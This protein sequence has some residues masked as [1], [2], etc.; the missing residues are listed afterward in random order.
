MTGAASVSLDALHPEMQLRQD[1]P[2]QRESCGPLP[3]GGDA[4][5]AGT[6]RGG[7]SA[8]IMRLMSTLDPDHPLHVQ[9]DIAELLGFA[10]GIIA[11]GAVS[12][13]E[14]Q[15]LHAWVASHPATT[16]AWPLPPLIERL[17]RI[18]RDGV[19]DDAERAELAALLRAIDKG[20]E[21]VLGAEKLAVTLPLDAP[22]PQIRWQGSAFVLVGHFA[23]GK[24]E[25]CVQ[26]VQRRG[27]RL[28]GDVAED[29]DYLVIGTFGSRDWEHTSFGPKIRRAAN[30]RAR[31]MPVAIVAERHWTACMHL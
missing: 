13:E 26:A 5:L 16:G 18:F 27:G 25:A 30:Y 6:L 10:R 8:D 9:R 3:A 12:A 29:T 14:A 17:E 20:H 1:A 11:D 28:Q 15:A 31:G 21:Q 2:R 4:D 19:A 22:A 7:K 24:P 23:F